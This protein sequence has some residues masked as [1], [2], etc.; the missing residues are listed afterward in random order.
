MSGGDTTCWR[1]VHETMINKLAAHVTTHNHTHTAHPAVPH[2]RSK[3]VS[4]RGE[5]THGEKGREGAASKRRTA[6]CGPLLPSSCLPSVSFFSSDS[7]QT[8][9]FSLASHTHHCR[10]SGA[11]PA[12]VNCLGAF[13][14]ISGTMRF[15]RYGLGASSPLI[16][17]PQYQR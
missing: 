14:F 10:G 7:L 9:F 15:S 8:H 13:V 3:R 1:Q 5:V 17:T 12:V 16:T 2:R 11:V 4:C 6:G